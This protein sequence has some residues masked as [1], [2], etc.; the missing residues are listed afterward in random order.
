M[1]PYFS[2]NFVD[3]FNCHILEGLQALPEESIQMVMTSPPYWGLRNYAGGEDIV[4]GGDHECSHQWR[5]ETQGLV[6]ENR[7]NL[8][9]ATQEEA[10][11]ATETAFIQKY[12]R[13]PSGTC[14][15]C[16][17]WRGQ[18]GLE[19]IWQLY[20]EHLVQ[21]SREIRRV[22]KKEGSYFLVLGDTYASSPKGNKEPSGLQSRNYGVGV[23]VPMKRNVQWG[24]DNIT[25]P[26]Q[27]LLIPYR[28]AMA[29]QEDGWILR[30]EIIWHKPN[31]MPSSQKDR[32]TC[33]TER[34]FRFIKNDR[35][36]LWRNRETGEW[37]DT[38]PTKEENYPHETH[39]ADGNKMQPLWMGF[40][41]YFELDAIRVPHS[42]ATIKR[43]SQSTVFDQL[44]GIK[45]DILRGNPSSGNASRYNRMVQSLAFNLRVR[46][47]K[48]G[49]GGAYVQG[50]EV[51]Q[52]SASEQE[53]KQY[54]YPE[55]REHRRKPDGR[56][57]KDHLAQPPEPEVDPERAFHAKGKNPGD[58]L[59]SHSK[60]IETPLES[61]YV[62][63]GR[64]PNINLMKKMGM[65]RS[66]RSTALGMDPQGKNPG[67]VVEQTTVR[68]KSWMST[69]GHPYTHKATGKPQNP[70]D[71]WS[72]TTQP[73]PEAHFAVYPE[74]VCVM[75]I[76]A[77][78]RPGDTVLDPFAGSG[79]TGVVAK[80]LGRRAILI[81]VVPKYCE[82]AKRRVQQTRP[83]EML[84][85]MSQL[86]ME[87]P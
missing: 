73:F 85:K 67:D 83:N 65:V 7:N 63:T 36:I 76:L 34:I 23:E 86:E 39:D 29:L 48:R 15:L 21:I 42:S 64:N 43:A 32:L 24:N 77:C 33:T 14:V 55:G 57:E 41:H 58:V 62:G 66:E 46:D 56:Y 17:A 53:V 78:S 27:K 40:D 4:W 31:S 20:V 61:G 87:A 37:R 50:G 1:E 8:A 54:Q 10:R 25:R 60:Y 16:S 19:P 70:G 3:I 74:K 72:L 22:L 38:K 2:D 13:L 30:D 80:K 26:K 84:E 44:G 18:L 47:A 69:P 71:F 35:T 11:G 12:D 51:K 9:R 68:H 82:V 6:Y 59:S 52:L 5:D 81:D 75:P 49:K 28:V 79:T 45:Q